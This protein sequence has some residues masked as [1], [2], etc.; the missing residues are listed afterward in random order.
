VPA[1]RPPRLPVRQVR[2]GPAVPLTPEEPFADPATIT[3]NGVRWIH[4]PKPRQAAQD[5]D[6]F[7]ELVK[8]N[9]E[10]GNAMVTT[11]ER[12]R[13]AETLNAAYRKTPEEFQREM[14]ELL[15]RIAYTAGE[16]STMRACELLQ[17]KVEDFRDRGWIQ[18]PGLDRLLQCWQNYG[19]HLESEDSGAPE[20]IETG[21]V[22][23]IEDDGE[24]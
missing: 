2:R 6:L 20:P 1:I 23:V 3:S 12:L 24:P 4:I 13:V 17:Q 9:Q 21:D 7:L 15:V 8:A 5:P 16:I 10:L 14:V 19:L 11:L 22:I 18:G